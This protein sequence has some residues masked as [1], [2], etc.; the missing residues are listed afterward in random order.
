MTKK[1][2][3]AKVAELEKEVQM[4]NKYSDEYA[5]IC[6]GYSEL[7]DTLKSELTDALDENKKLK[8][9]KK[10][11]VEE[12]KP[13]PMFKVGDRVKCIT[14]GLKPFGLVG[15]VRYVDDDSKPYAVE[16]DRY[17]DGHEFNGTLRDKGI[18]CKEGC[19]WWVCEEDLEL[20]K[21]EP[22]FKVGD[23][24]ECITHWYKT[25]L[26]GKIGTI[27]KLLKGSS[28]VYTVDFDEYIGGHN[29]GGTCKPGH[30]SHIRED[31]LELVK[32]E[33][34][35]KVG[36]RVKAIKPTSS[37]MNIVGKVGTIAH[38]IPNWT[39]YCVEFDEYING[40]SCGGN[41]KDGHGWNCDEDTLEPVKEEPKFKVGDRVKCVKERVGLGKVFG[42]SGTIT[43][44]DYFCYSIEWDED[45]DGHNCSGH[46]KPD[47]GWWVGIRNEDVL[48]LVKP[49][50][51][52]EHKFEV[53]DRVKVISEP[54]GLPSALGKIGTIKE[55]DV[56]GCHIEMDERIHLRRK[57]GY[58][59]G[60]HVYC[61]FK[62]LE[63]VDEPKFKVGD[64]VTVLSCGRGTVKGLDPAGIHTFAIEFDKSIGPVGH[65]CS[66]LC[67]DRHGLWV[68]EDLIKL[69]DEK[70]ELKRNV[71]NAMRICSDDYLNC[72]CCPYHG[73]EENCSYALYKD[74]IKLLED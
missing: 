38:V 35:F 73:R 42:K 37:N 17:I 7:V 4:A 2:L 58:K 25:H 30:G 68:H 56:R 72:S 18:E 51:K 67:K 23:R 1:E 9:S 41:A 53:G 22:K 43:Y 31:C 26:I 55:V 13:V 70:A 24:V 20:V 45:I 12:V 50:P 64:R 61:L 5:D 10:E 49:E 19:G 8:E 46:T 36:D 21:P 54:C 14:H 63:L 71:L 28:Y 52:F 66:G 29:G 65:T 15:T 33:P 57:P 39:G 11:S 59:D 48:E 27:K 44:I 3:E 47:H 34:K 69:I 16:F 60:H 74:A 6:K 32:E 40:H 62:R